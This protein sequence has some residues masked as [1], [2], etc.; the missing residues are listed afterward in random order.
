MDAPEQKQI[1]VTYNCGGLI[2][3]YFPRAFSF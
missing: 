1:G 2:S 3:F